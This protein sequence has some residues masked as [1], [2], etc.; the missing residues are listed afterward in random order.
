MQLIPLT[1]D[2]IQ[3]L[4]VKPEEARKQIETEK[5]VHITPPQSEGEE[6][7]GGSVEG[8]VGRHPY[9][10]TRKLSSFPRLG[11]SLPALDRRA[12]VPRVA[13]YI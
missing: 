7:G 5:T 3:G 9:S 6:I 13:T 1:N 10:R 11:V 12:D 8:D 2:D 4:L